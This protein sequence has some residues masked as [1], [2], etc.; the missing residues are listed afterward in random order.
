MKNVFKDLAQSMEEEID[1]E[2][3]D[4]VM[5]SL[6][7]EM[8]M[9]NVEYVMTEG[10]FGLPESK[11]YTPAS[12]EDPVVLIRIWENGEETELMVG[13]K[14]SEIEVVEDNDEDDMDEDED[15]ERDIS[16]LIKNIFGR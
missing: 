5:F 1:V 15:E 4:I 6:G 9:G 14:Y 8:M 10:F 3:G 12:S 2:D 13:R 7:G 16:K 11:F